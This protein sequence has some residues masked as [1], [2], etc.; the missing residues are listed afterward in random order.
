MRQ[1]FMIGA[2]V[3]WVAIN[4][5]GSVIEMNVPLMQETEV[6]DDK[7]NPLTQKGILE[8]AQ[9]PELTD[10]N[11]VT[12]FTKLGSYIKV[13]GKVLTLYHQSLWQGSTILIYYFIILPIG[14][15]FWVVFVMAIRGVGSS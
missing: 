2:I 7:G 8:S 14:I 11:I 15:S 3:L 4:I 6:T 13:I 10:T 5:I 12:M 1:A 9:E